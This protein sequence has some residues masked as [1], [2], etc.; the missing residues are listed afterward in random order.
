MQPTVL[1]VLCPVGPRLLP[2]VVAAT[3]LVAL[4]APAFPP[5]PPHV[6]YG[7]VRDEMGTPLNLSNT[8]IILEPTNGVQL[9]TALIVD[10]EPG[11]N[12]RLS[13][14]IDA[15]IAP[16]LYRPTALR[17]QVGFRIR[18][19]VG[20]TT[21]LPVEMIGNLR[22]LGRSAEKT[23][24]D[25]TLG[26]D[27]DGDGLPDSWERLLIAMLGGNLTLADIRPGDDSDGDGI[28]NHDE[29]IA[30]TY[31]FDPEDGFR[32]AWVD[33]AAASPRL[34]FLG[35]AGRTYTLQ[36]STN[37]PAWQ[38]MTFRLAGAVPGAGQSTYRATD[39]RWV[40]IEPVLPPGVSASAWFFRARAQ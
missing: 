11:V 8:Q 23:R 24:I 15:G 2:V 22:N 32:L 28:S 37:L 9:T 12:Y 25:L 17:P 38:P 1:S 40:Q 39:V 35:I 14:P 19:Q 33:A 26:E 4:P 16:D 29:Y 3:L 20:T 31:A 6:I 13:V 36:A 34:E 10:P 27:T 30:G 21:Y 18:V 5:A 7:T